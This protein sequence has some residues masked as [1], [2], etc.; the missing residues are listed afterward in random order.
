VA[1]GVGGDLG[2]VGD[3]QHLVAAGQL[4][5]AAADGG[6]GAAADPGVDL[7][8]DQGRGAVDRGQH[9][10][11]G[12]HDPGQ[13]APGGGPASGRRGAPGWA[14]SRKSTRSRP[15]SV[16]AGGGRRPRGR[17]RR[18]SCS[19]ATTTS[20]LGMAR[21]ASSTRTASPRRAAAS[22]PGGGEGRPGPGKLAP[23][24][25]RLGL[26]GFGAQGAALQLG[27][28][29]GGLAGEGEH[30]RLVVAVLALQVAEQGHAQVDLFQA[31][32]VDQHRLGVGAQAGG[33][34]ADL[35]G[36]RLGPLG[37]LAE[38]RS[39]PPGPWMARPRRRGR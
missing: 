34:V 19:T 17:R 20:A 15:S 33:E 24:L 5:Q 16:A 21:S 11:Q 18:S 2:Q 13:L 36:Q 28:P 14:A 32:R 4:G 39:W 25:G 37:Q 26:E 23:E 1:V 9:D 31:G 38:G 8:E 6:G 35:G 12:E 30:R 3:D 29:R 22:C 7:V 10:P 27:E